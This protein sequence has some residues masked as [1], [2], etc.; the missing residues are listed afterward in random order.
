MALWDVNTCSVVDKYLESRNLQ[1]KF[2][3]F[4]NDRKDGDS[5]IPRNV[6]A[7]LGNCMGLLHKKAA[8]VIFIPVLPRKKI[9]ICKLRNWFPL[10]PYLTIIE[11]EYSYVT[12]ALFTLEL[13]L[14]QIPKPCIILCK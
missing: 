2:S 1:P 11:L 9:V 12:C 4:K 6:G 5:G 8:I 10:R 3:E 7:P 13:L 14:R